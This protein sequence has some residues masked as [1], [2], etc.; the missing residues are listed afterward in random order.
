MN[1]KFEDIPRRIFL[2]S[3]ALQTLQTY[4]GFLYENEPL[5]REDRIRR[6]PKGI[7]K[8]EA[9]RLIMQV[10]ERAPFEFA[11]SNNSFVEV[12][13]RG[14][15]GYLQWAH[16]VLDHWMACL[17][18]SEKPCVSS[19]ALAA[20]SSDSYDYLGAGDRALLKDAI[21]LGC[22]AFLTME[23][24]LPK[25]AGHIERT[26]GIRILS[27]IEMWDCIRPLAALFR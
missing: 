10:A 5:L 6:D 20:I 3:S 11:L 8:L 14:D 13:D 27:P 22:D 1:S 9:L 25:N 15:S 17:E 4:G 7:L 16:D 12:R 18:G 21:V 23:N 19:T 24:K 2:D 26:L